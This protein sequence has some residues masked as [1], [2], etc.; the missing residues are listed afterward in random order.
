LQ[1]QIRESYT[2]LRSRWATHGNQR[3]R[4]FVSQKWDRR[5][6]LSAGMITGVAIALKPIAR[7]DEPRSMLR[8]EDRMTPFPATWYRPY[9]SHPAAGA[10]SSAWVQIDLGSALKIDA[11][12]IYPNFDDARKSIGFPL[13]M[14]VEGTADPSFGSP[15]LLFDSGFSELPDP[16][17]HIAYLSLANAG[18]VRYI[19]FTGTS[20]RPIKKA[21]GEKVASYGLSFAKIEVLTAGRDVAESRPVSADPATEN[22]KDLAQLTRKPRPVGEGILT[23]NPQNVTDPRSWKRISNRAEVPRRGVELGEG[24]LREAMQNNIDYLL[25]SFSVDEMLR[26][27]RER[28]GKPVQADLRPPIQ[29]W[30]TDLPGSSAGRFLM[31]AANTLRWQQHEELHRRMNAIVDGIADCRQPNGYIMAYPEDSIMHSERAGYTRAWVTHGLLEAGYTGHPKAFELL[32][33]YYDWFD[34]CPYLAKLLRGTAQGVQGMVANTRMYLSPV[35][36]AE[37]IEVVQRYFQ[38]NYWLNGL[39][40]RDETMVWQY[41][42]D[43]PHNY[44]L[45]DIEAYF[46]LYRATGS[47]LYKEAVQGAWQ[48][49][50]DNWEHIGGSIAI[51]EFGEFPPKSYRLKPQ[52][53]FCETGELCGSSFWA[54]LNQRFQLL[55]PDNEAYAT[56]IEK[57]IYNVGIA[58]QFIGKGFFYHARLVGKKGDKAVGYCTNSCCEGQGT[59]LAGSIPEHLYSIV[60]AGTHP[61]LYIH[62]FAPSTIRWTQ[63]DSRAEEEL[64]LSMRTTFPHDSTVELRFDVSS[65]RRSVIRVRT[66]SWATAEMPIRVDGEVAAV[67]KPGS[68][69]SLDRTWKSGDSVSFTLPAGFRLTRYSGM[70]HIAGSERYALEYGPILLAVAN[71]DEARLHASGSSV[72]SFKNQLK[73]IP[74]QPLCFTIVGNPDHRYMPYYAI[75]EETFTCFP[76]IENGSNLVIPGE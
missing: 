74:G 17:D 23:D 25:T 41:P 1:F 71:S 53:D 10:S 44:L 61:G 50:R 39:A 54:F 45:T 3:E 35:G 57:S 8:L 46:D 38:E 58:S 16:G 4:L 62:M 69:V 73:A 7:A 21:E 36:R 65:P 31:G 27:F 5:E 43:R 34:R 13:Q 75:K 30:D 70:D 59:R 24:V 64:K 33:G 22:S 49:Y 48:L 32:R 11:V 2:Y 29:F 28:A 52:F 20:L 66:P 26:P 47:Q 14:K 76:I 15:S 63:R 6:V 42:Y 55:D 51:T 68:Y 40:R 60:P 12:R 19:R 9:V 72:Q 37:D 18:P 67:G 56:E